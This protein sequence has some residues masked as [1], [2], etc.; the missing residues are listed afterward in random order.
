[1][2]VVL[3]VG[4]SGQRGRPRRRYPPTQVAATTPQPREDYYY[5]DYYDDYSFQDYKYGMD[6]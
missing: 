5:D 4:V 3:V 1:M 2:T 6:Q